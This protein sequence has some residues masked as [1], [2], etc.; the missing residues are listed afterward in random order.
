MTS[1]KTF[2]DADTAKVLGYSYCTMHA[3][4][5][6]AVRDLWWAVERVRTGF[7]TN[8]LCCWKLAGSLAFEALVRWQH[9]SCGLLSTAEFIEVAEYRS[10]D[11]LNEACRQMRTWK[12]NF[13]KIIVNQRESFQQTVFTPELLA[14]QPETHGNSM[15]V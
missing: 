6:F 14:Y 7:T 15:V 3:S 1:Q 9:P 5:A 12:C 4:D 11:Y 10:L 13:L 8:L 2:Y